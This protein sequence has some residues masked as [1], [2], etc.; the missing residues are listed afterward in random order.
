[1]GKYDIRILRDN[2]RISQHGK[3][4][5]YNSGDWLTVGRMEAMTL[6]A[7]GKAELQDTNGLLD[8]TGTA[9]YAPESELDEL[10]LFFTIPTIGINPCPVD[11][12]DNQYNLFLDAGYCFKDKKSPEIIR[13]PSKFAFVFEYMK[14]HDVVLI[15]RDYNTTV[16]AFGRELLA[17]EK[18]TFDNRVMSYQTC[19]VGI[20][21][22]K[23]GLEFYQAWQDEKE[24][25][26]FNALVRALFI[27]K[28]TVYYLPPEWGLLS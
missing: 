4:E 17:T 21:N 20:Q 12:I 28:P 19:A 18:H 3:I 14:E 11:A 26:E 27:V 1:M 16:A 5:I 15:L 2:T 6:V 13:N 22:T 8:T 9:V 23:T 10:T 24:N 25:G 7:E